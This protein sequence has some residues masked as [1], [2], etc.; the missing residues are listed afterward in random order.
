MVDTLDRLLFTA[1]P[2]EV[3]RDVLKAMTKPM[4]TH[5]SSDYKKLHHSVVERLKELLGTENDIF[6]IPASSTGAMEAGVRSAV[7]RNILHLT[8]GSFAE[9]W[10]EISR[11]NGKT[12]TVVSTEWGK[13]IVPELIGSAADGVEAVAVTHNESSTGVMNPLESIAAHL[14]K[15]PD[16][17]LMVDAVTSAFGNIIDMKSVKPDLLLFGT[18]KALALPP[19]MAIA[20]VSERLLE[21]AK[22]V[23]DRGRYL[24]LV[25]IKEF[26]DRDLVPTTPP[27]SLLYALD[28]QLDRIKEE[29]MQKRADRHFR[30]AEMARKWA[31][32]H[33]SLFSQEGF[34][35]NTI[36]CVNNTS[37]MD[38]KQ[39][40]EGLAKRGY[41]IAE[42]YGKLKSK[43][44]R[45]GH[46]GDLTTE[47]MGG[48]LD[49]LT[50][51][52]A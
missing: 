36:T 34:H 19:G 5:R 50:E 18:Q 39:I 47:E 3:R 21:K 49:S 8:C 30:M 9:R 37:G 13:A 4:I 16:V 6:L 46:M 10:V 22:G 26:A 45:I 7:S 2:V 29:G 25:E 12:A 48:L 43:T 38:F 1:G 42:G 40:D 44:F 24:D 32:D 35:S 17:L 52:T 15:T 20:V 51:V 28:Y 33:M 31:S 27:I 41:Q 14:R 11:S 23:G